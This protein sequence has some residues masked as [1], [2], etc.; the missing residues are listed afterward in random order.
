VDR[1]AVDFAALDGLVDSL[2]AHIDATE[3]RI[4]EFVVTAHGNHA[5]AVNTNV[6]IWR[7]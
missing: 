4:R 1:L 2:A 7:V 3:Q 6:R 5:D